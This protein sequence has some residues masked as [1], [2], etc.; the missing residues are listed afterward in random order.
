M[1]TPGHPPQG[2]LGNTSGEG[3]ALKTRDYPQL[4]GSWWPPGGWDAMPGHLTTAQRGLRSRGFEKGGAFGP[5]V[6]G[7][8]PGGQLRRRGGAVSFLTVR[9]P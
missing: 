8:G 5:G 2:P 3:C 1:V 4:G 6:M 9:Q 7:R